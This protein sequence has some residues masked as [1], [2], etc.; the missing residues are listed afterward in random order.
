M[1]HGD[2]EASV[3]IWD[4]HALYAPLG[5]REGDVKRW[6]DEH[7]G[8]WGKGFLEDGTCFV[9]GFPVFSTVFWM[10]GD[11]VSLA[12]D[13]IPRLIE[14]CGRAEKLAEGTPQVELLRRIRELAERA[15]AEGGE[16]E[17]GYQ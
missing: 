8:A 15:V 3:A 7:E 17:F 9:P 12:G 4:V 14:E 10:W 16:L 5:V 1:P 11:F 2:R 6:E 13:E